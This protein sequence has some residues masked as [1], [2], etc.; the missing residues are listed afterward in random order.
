MIMRRLHDKY[1]LGE[2]ITIENFVIDMIIIIIVIIIIIIA[3]TIMVYCRV[4]NN[5][6]RLIIYKIYIIDLHKKRKTS[7]IY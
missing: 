3:I 2:P 1:V 5:K 6:E 4:S 7:I